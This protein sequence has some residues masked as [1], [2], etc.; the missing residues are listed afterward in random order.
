MAQ[1]IDLNI[2]SLSIN[3]SIVSTV[4]E[5]QSNEKIRPNKVKYR[6]R[7]QWNNKFEFIL[8]CMA[9][10][11]GYAKHFNHKFYFI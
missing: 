3:N 11:I 10:A 2:K 8:A 1:Q 6:E 5:I 9:Y 4:N 7:E